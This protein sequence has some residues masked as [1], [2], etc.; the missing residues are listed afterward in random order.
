MTNRGTDRSDQTSHPQV[1]VRWRGRAADV[2]DERTPLIRALGQAG[3][4][5]CNAGSPVAAGQSP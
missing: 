1:R 3:V 4:Y 5:T 2:D